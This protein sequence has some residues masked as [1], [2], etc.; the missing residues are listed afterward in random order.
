MNK[1][2]K[3]PCPFCLK[4]TLTLT[5]DEKDIPHFGK[6]YIYSM[7]CS[8][9]K[10][11]KVDLEAAETK[12][13]TRQTF[14]INSAKDMNVHI[15]KSAEATIKF[16]Q[17]KMAVESGPNSEGYVSNIEGVLERFEKVIKQ[18]KE[19]ADDE[20]IKK[21]CKNLLKKIWKIKL[22]DIPTKIVIEDPSGN[23]AIISPK[24]KVEKLK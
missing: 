21:N 14:E 8:S 1:L 13:P 19:N 5:E 4:S 9:C 10:Y 11:E 23:S 22:G 2:T 20:G 15:V 3:Q 6:T 7:T 18:E 24:T 17:L 16:P 12:E